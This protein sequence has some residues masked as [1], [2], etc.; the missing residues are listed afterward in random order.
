MPQPAIAPGAATIAA[1]MPNHASPAIRL[2]PMKARQSGGATVCAAAG[3]VTGARAVA[4]TASAS[5]STWVSAAASAV[6][7]KSE[8]GA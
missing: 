1:V 7:G 6:A 4:K 8:A 5:T 3:G 2:G